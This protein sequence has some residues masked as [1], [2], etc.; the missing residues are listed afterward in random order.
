VNLLSVGGVPNVFGLATKHYKG[1]SGSHGKFATQSKK[2]EHR[3]REFLSQK[4][5]SMQPQTQHPENNVA[6]RRRKRYI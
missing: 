4:R 1:P 6:G 2:H 3:Q 5:N